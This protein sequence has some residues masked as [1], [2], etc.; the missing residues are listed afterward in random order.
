MKAIVLKQPGDVSNLVQADVAVPS[1]KPDEILVAVKAI[2]INPADAFLRANAEFQK[3]ILG[4]SAEDELVILGWDISGIITETGSSVTR[5]K[6]GD[7]VFG[8]V[9]FPGHGKAYAEYV[10][11]P[12]SN[13]AIKPANISFNEA[14]AAT[15]AALTAWQSLVTYGKVLQGDKVLIHSAAGGVG[16]MAVQI[17]KALGAYVIGVGSAENTNFILSKG[18]DEAIDYKKQSFETLVHDVDLIID[19]VSATPE[20]LYRSAKTLKKGGRLIS[21]V[22]AFD[23]EL[24]K[25]L[26]EKEITGHRLMVASNGTD[27]EKIADLLQS[28][29]LKPEISR[30]FSFA[31]IKEA[32]LQ[33]ETGKTRGKIIID[34]AL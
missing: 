30:V 18:A 2:S 3:I 25:I 15:L 4:V 14:A 7:E 12:E 6:K 23:E 9:N 24:Q 16:H 28:G 20:H 19:G 11:A 32:H 21:L 26:H 27:M 1:I 10:A 22:A 33:I 34:P 13:L 29:K 8:M 5:F 31:Q 17:A